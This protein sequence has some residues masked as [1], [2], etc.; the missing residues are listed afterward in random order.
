MSAGRYLEDL[1]V[2]DTFALGAFRLDQAD[3]LDFARRFDPQPFHLDPA[4]ALQTVAGGLIASGWMTG[5]IAMRLLCEAAPFGA[6]PIL[7]SGVDDLRWPAPVRPGDVLTGTA[8]IT[9][10]VAS[11][12]RPERG[13]VRMKVVLVNQAGEVV[14]SMMPRVVVPTRPSALEAGL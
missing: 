3:M 4:A 14:F 8:E 5:S 10:V 12:S 7:G 9:E 13:A 2:G 6:T 11:V 1:G